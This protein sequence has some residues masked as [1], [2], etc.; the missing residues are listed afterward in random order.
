M[1]VLGHCTGPGKSRQLQHSH[2]QSVCY[3]LVP[4]RMTQ[5]KPRIICASQPRTR[6]RSSTHDEGLKTLFLQIAEQYRGWRTKLSIARRRVP[7]LCC[8][9]NFEGNC[10]RRVAAA[11]RKHLPMHE[12]P[13]HLR[14]FGR[15]PSSFDGSAAAAHTETK[16]EPRNAAFPHQ[17]S[18]VRLLTRRDRRGV[19]GSQKRRLGCATSNGCGGWV[20]AC[21]SRKARSNAAILAKRI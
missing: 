2:F 14:H 1:A 7:N 19:I 20:D 9:I 5:T 6:T 12:A 10:R 18:D 17:L 21:E 15:T 4:W 16:P 11:A 3:K 13:L 8:A